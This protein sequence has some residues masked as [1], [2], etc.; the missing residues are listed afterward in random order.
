MILEIDAGNTRVKWRVTR[1]PHDEPSTLPSEGFYLMTENTTDHDLEFCRYLSGLGLAGMERVLA[2]NVRGPGFRQALTDCALS[3]WGIRPQ[4]AEPLRFCAGVTNGYDSPELLG[5]DRWLAL[6]AAYD[7]TRQDC[8]ILNCGTTITLDL[9]DANGVHLGG[10]IVPG[11]QMMR[12]GLQ[13]KVPRLVSEDDGFNSTLPG[14]NTSA[15]ICHG[16]LAMSLGFI[17]LIKKSDEKSGLLP[18]WVISGGDAELIKSQLDWNVELEPS[19]V[20]D[21]LSLAFP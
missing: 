2:A 3:E 19:L 17:E 18:R 15:A 9:V 6:L 7:T 5:V 14:R 20:M 16:I 10:Y 8:R 13:T 11:L 21:G 1:A 12:Q 4:F